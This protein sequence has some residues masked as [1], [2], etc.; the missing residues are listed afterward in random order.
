VRYVPEP[1]FLTI[2]GWADAAVNDHVRVFTA[3][4]DND[5]GAAREGM[6]RH[7]RHAGELLAEHFRQRRRADGS[8]PVAGDGAAPPTTTDRTVAEPRSGIR[9]SG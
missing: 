2:E 5:S 8:A 4:E 9:S 3:L 6:R 1:Y 7:I